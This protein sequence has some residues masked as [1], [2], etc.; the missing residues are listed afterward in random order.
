[1]VFTTTVGVLKLSETEDPC[2]NVIVFYILK[3]REPVRC[4][5]PEAE[6]PAQER[7]SFSVTEISVGFRFK[8]YRVCVEG[9]VEGVRRVKRACRRSAV[10]KQ[11][12]WGRI[13]TSW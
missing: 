9:G 4:E 13:S 1:M 3:F 2:A 11:R 7:V 8:N 5:L 12:G 6:A 10:L